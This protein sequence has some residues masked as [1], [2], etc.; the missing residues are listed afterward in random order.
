MSPLDLL[1][2]RP[3]ARGHGTSAVPSAPHTRFTLPPERSATRPPE[4]RG[5]ARDGVRLLVA[6][7][8]ATTHATFRDLPGHLR[9][10]DLVVVNTSATLPAALDG[11]WRD[12]AVVLHLSTRLEDDTWIVELRRPDGASP[13]L[14]AACGDEVHLPG[15]GVATLLEPAG[16]PI[17]G[18]SGGIRLWRAE[19]HTGAHRAGWLQRHGRPITYGHQAE[20]FPLEDYQTIFA[21]RPGSAEMASAARPFT[22]RLVTDLVSRG[23]RIVPITLHAGVSSLEAGEPPRPEW[24][25]VPAA[26]GELVEWTRRSGGRIVAVGTTVTRALESAVDRHGRVQPARGW[27]DVV[28]GPDRPTL[29]VDGLLTGWH[30]PDASHLHLLEAVA[31]PDLVARAYAS[32]LAGPYL[33]HE[34][35]DSCLLLP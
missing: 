11:T 20:R 26:T 1:P 8:S 24:F 22:P 7:P 16:D 4:A 3:R 9:P 32:A 34:F 23:V 15:P 25:E 5:L 21:R 28:L 30:G 29:V 12:Q 31:G 27:T 35:G 18:A 17:G 33:W 13:V 2:S 19:L 10:G 6:R 14:T